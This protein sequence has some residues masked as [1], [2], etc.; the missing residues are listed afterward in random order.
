MVVAA[1]CS[2]TTTASVVA[3]SADNPQGLAS[4]K[5]LAPKCTTLTR[6]TT[7]PATVHA[8]YEAKIYAKVI[9]YLRELNTDIGR[10]VKKDEVLG[11]L[12]VPEMER[13]VE[14]QQK[15]LERLAAE[16]VRAKTFVELARA[17]LESARAAVEQARAE[18][19]R[20]EAQVV[21]DY[22]EHQRIEELVQNK[23]IEDRLLDEATKKCTSSRAAKA[24]AEAGV[25]VA[26]AQVHVCDAKLKT[27]EA[28]LQIAQVEPQVARKKLDELQAMSAYAILKAPFEG[29]VTQRHIDLGDLVRTT[30]TASHQPLFSVSQTDTVRI[31]M[32]VPEKDAPWVKN[33]NAAAVKLQSLPGRA[34]EGKVSRTSGSLDEGTRTMLVEI[35]LPNPKGELLPG[36]YGEATVVLE[37][38]KDAV[39][40]PATTVRHDEQGRSFIYVVTAD[41]VIHKTDVAIGLDNGT[42]LEIL[43]NLHDGQR[44][45][46]ATLATLKDGQRIAIQE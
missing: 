17:N 7:Q 35:D 44:I 16:E 42:E 9:G 41:D 26:N 6:T 36:M 45:V 39:V 21:A 37:E 33:G 28:D 13:A 14:S 10:R 12:W 15:T 20:S 18:V 31:R 23:S 22:A 34:F 25:L 1:G 5:V 4:V 29:V 40:L 27:A 3:G 11:V 38:R 19:A 43:C 24:A 46:D 2:R 30:E 32:T 8:N